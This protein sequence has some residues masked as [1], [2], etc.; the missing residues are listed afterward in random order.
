M[1]KSLDKNINSDWFDPEKYAYYIDPL[2]YLA[3]IVFYCLGLSI[4]YAVILF[5]M[6]HQIFTV[7][8]L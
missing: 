2:R 1:N 5:I 6:H 3:K 8:V 7:D 4:F